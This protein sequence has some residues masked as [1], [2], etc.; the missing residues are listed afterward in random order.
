MDELPDEKLLPEEEFQTLPEEDRKT[1][2][3]TEGEARV[4]E[5]L[6]WMSEDI[7]GKKLCKKVMNAYDL[8]ESMAYKW[9][10]KAKEVELAQI[11]MTPEELKD[12]CRKMFLKH[13]KSKDRKVSISAT[14]ELAKHGGFYPSEKVEVTNKYD[15][16]PKDDLEK[17][18]QEEG[19]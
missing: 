2:S 17:L 6:Y 10:K 9:I 19:L 18:A 7:L 14:R 15:E 3:R 8:C 5:I 4:H 12:F 16:M 1:A 13:T 11:K